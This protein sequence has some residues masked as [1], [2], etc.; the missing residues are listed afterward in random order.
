MA[1][2]SVRKYLGL[3]TE[4]II[5]QQKEIYCWMWW[6]CFTSSALMAVA[7]VLQNGLI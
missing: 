1:K 3:D 4:N 5:S 7:E 6:I 2:V